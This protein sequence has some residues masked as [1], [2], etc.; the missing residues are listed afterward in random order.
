M[1]I[2]LILLLRSLCNDR[3][4]HRIDRPQKARAAATRPGRQTVKRD[5]RKVGVS[6]AAGLVPGVDVFERYVKQTTIDLDATGFRISTDW[7]RGRCGSIQSLFLGARGSVQS[8]VAMMGGTRYALVHPPIG[9]SSLWYPRALLWHSSSRTTVRGL[10]RSRPFPSVLAELERVIERANPVGGIHAGPIQRVRCNP[11][12][13]LVITLDDDRT[14]ARVLDDGHFTAIAPVTIDPE[15]LSVDSHVEY[16]PLS[17]SPVWILR[18]YATIT[19]P[20]PTTTSETKRVMSVARD[21]RSSF[22]Y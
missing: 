9:F 1:Y 10:E 20:Q 22:H 14:P 2:Y 18:T 6:L 17:V 16:S 4:R 5:G 19:T 15:R 11:S 12:A 8:A 13:I 7:H 21:I 3:L